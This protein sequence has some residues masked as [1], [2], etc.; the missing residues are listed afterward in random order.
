[1]LVAVRLARALIPHW[2]LV[3]RRMVAMALEDYSHIIAVGSS[4]TVNYQLRRGLEERGVQ[5]GRGLGP[6]DWFVLPLG[7]AATALETDF[8][9]F[10]EPAGCRCVGPAGEYWEIQSAAGA[11]SL[12][13]LPRE[14]AD[15]APTADAWFQFGQWLG[16]RRA[17]CKHVLGRAS[18]RV[19]F[20]RSSP[21]DRPDSPEEIEAFARIAERCT[22]AAVTVAAVFVGRAP[23]VNAP[24]VTFEV[25]RSW[26][27]SLGAHELDWNNDYGWGP[28]WQGH[29]PSWNDVW[30]RV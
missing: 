1:M 5:R 29:S 26:P 10:F 19:L 8:R 28:A 3:P 9:D 22:A 14:L 25:D 21:I 4:C 16:K 17:I 12:H 24:I 2:R 18:G 20:V 13:H 27:E 11:L 30:S 6:F 7:V 15:L 23:A